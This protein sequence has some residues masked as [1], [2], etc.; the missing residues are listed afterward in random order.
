[1]RRAIVALCIISCGGKFS[2][3]IGEASE[4][5]APKTVY[6]DPSAVDRVCAPPDPDVISE[7]GVDTVVVEGVPRP[8][9]H[10]TVRG[11]AAGDPCCNACA[12][13]PECPYLL[14]DS[15]GRKVCL[16]GPRFEA[17]GNECRM[18][19]DPIRCDTE[20]RYRFIGRYVG[21]Q[22]LEVSSFC[23]LP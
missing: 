7:R 5:A 1:M 10:C 3:P 16:H 20:N 6:D 11:C 15:E 12:T 17:H 2:Q 23:R 18:Q 19:C 14:D 9:V 22:K 4:A 8:N 13:D 21:L